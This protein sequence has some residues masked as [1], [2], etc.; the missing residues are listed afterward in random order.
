MAAPNPVYIH[1]YPVLLIV[2]TSKFEFRNEKYYRDCR[3]STRDETCGVSE[4]REIGHR[5]RYC[6][7][8]A[9]N[10]I[11]KSSSKPYYNY[12]CVLSHSTNC[13]T[14]TIAL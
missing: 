5:N 4:A 2:Y 9:F 1:V 13:S 8:L 6:S 10:E 3:K 11:V 14:I 12:C 7:C